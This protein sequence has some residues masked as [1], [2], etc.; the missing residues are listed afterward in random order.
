MTTIVGIKTNSGSIDAVVLGADTQMSFSYDN[1]KET[2]KKPFYKIITGDFWALAHV[3][4]VTDDLRKFYNKLT[5]P[6]R[7][8]DFDKLKI[9]EIILE[10]VKRKRF[11][12]V[13]ELNAE[14][15]MTEEEESKQNREEGYHEFLMAVN[16][17]QISLFSV[18][19]FGN[20]IPPKKDLNYLVLGTGG[21]V[22]RKYTEEKLEGDS[23]E[24]Q[25]VDIKRAFKL[26][27]ESLK[28][29]EASDINSSGPMDFVVIKKEGVFPYGR[30]I[31]KAIETAEESEFEN[32]IKENEEKK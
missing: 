31:R 22:A 21:D 12:E 1:K 27:R 17:P 29:S 24:S 28:A 16:E 32:I 10:S 19:A 30:R 7:Y 3:G 5:N 6:D 4:A 20:L 11:I 2:A 23:F 25:N 13:N 14:Y 18:D 15:A 8:K 9:K 26:C